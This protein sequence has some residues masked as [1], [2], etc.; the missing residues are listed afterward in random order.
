MDYRIDAANKI[1][2]RLA[3]EIAVLLRGK[4][5]PDFEPNLLPKNKVIV[6]NIGKISFSGK[7]LDQKKYFHYSGYHG[8][9][10]TSYLS[11]EVV[12]NPG[13]IFKKTVYDM[14]PKNKTRDK[15]IKNL[16]VK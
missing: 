13:K 9:L 1:F 4:N 15:I 12:K 2:G 10:R 7:K 16:I 14:L 3:T 8:G 6:E 11:K 5:K